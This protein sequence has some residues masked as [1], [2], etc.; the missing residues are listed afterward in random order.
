MLFRSIKINEQTV[1][2]FPFPIKI[3]VGGTPSEYALFP[4][5]PNPFN[6]STDMRYQIAD[7]RSPVHTSL[8]IFNL[9]G[10]EVRT[11]VDEPQ[12]PGSYTVT[13]DGRDEAG[14]EV[15]SG[16]YFYRLTAGGTS[17]DN[18]GAFSDTKRMLLLK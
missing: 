4:N 8:K 5:Y 6:P 13:W 15:P 12:E 11:V 10:Q 17:R 2:K 1:I 7:R 14:R 3:N 9:L 18:R 16:I